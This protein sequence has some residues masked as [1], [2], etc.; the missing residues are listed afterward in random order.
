MVLRYNG[1]VTANMVIRKVKISFVCPTSE[2]NVKGKEK[3]KKG[4]N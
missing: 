3:N 2:I 1:I 4:I